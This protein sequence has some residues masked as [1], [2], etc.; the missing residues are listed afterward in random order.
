MKVTFEHD[1]AVPTPIS[2]GLS[3]GDS[4]RLDIIDLLCHLGIGHSAIIRDETAKEP[5]IYSWKPRVRFIIQVYDLIKNT[6]HVMAW[7][8]WDDWDDRYQELRVWRVE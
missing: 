6:T 2:G 7:V 3:E 8:P 5:N 4:F 1:V